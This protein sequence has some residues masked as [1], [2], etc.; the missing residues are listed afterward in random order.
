MFSDDSKCLFFFFIPFN[1]NTGFTS[2]VLELK[3]NGGP[4]APVEMMSFAITV[5]LKEVCLQGVFPA[6]G[7]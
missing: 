3:M 6:K 5:P 1:F 2:L 7:S 4:I